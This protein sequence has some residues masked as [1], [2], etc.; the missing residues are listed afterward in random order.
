MPSSSRGQIRHYRDNAGLECDAVL[1]LENGKWAAIEIKLGGENLVKE[2]A[3]SLNRLKK[4]MLD[5][6]L[7]PPTF[8]MVLTA[9]GPMYKR[10]DGIY[11]VPITKL[12]D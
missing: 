4:K 12:K 11:V 10:E 8:M 9:V 7:T 6:N 5:N 1:H 3:D 2:G